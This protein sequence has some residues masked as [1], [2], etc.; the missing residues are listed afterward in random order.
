MLPFKSIKLVKI[1]KPLTTQFRRP[2]SKPTSQ[3]MK[4]AASIE[5]KWPC[6]GQKGLGLWRHEMG[7]DLCKKSKFHWHY[8][9]GHMQWNEIVNFYNRLCNWRNKKISQYQQ[10]FKKIQIMYMLHARCHEEY[11]L[12]YLNEPSAKTKYQKNVSNF[13]HF[14]IRF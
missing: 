4:G 6:M 8:A 2:A 5:Q 9:C 10:I 13:G 1:G 11:L 14:E 3:K 12:K 7:N